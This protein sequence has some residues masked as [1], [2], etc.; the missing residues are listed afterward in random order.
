[1]RLRRFLTLTAAVHVVLALAV[2]AHARA[3]GRD[4]GGRW[5]LATL[6]AGVVGVVGYRRS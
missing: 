2:C 1:M 4:D 5:A 3:T 6:V